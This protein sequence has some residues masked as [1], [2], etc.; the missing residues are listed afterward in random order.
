MLLYIAAHWDNFVA[1]VTHPFSL[2]L[3]KLSTWLGLMV[4]HEESVDFDEHRYKNGPIQLALNMT[5]SALEISKS[6]AERHLETYKGNVLDLNNQ[7]QSYERSINDYD[8]QIGDCN[9]EISHLNDVIDNLN[10]EVSN[11]NAKIH[12]SKREIVQLK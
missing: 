3:E 12:E 1:E 9:R 4:V 2:S 6:V 8:E 10:N 11:L 5:D 7:R